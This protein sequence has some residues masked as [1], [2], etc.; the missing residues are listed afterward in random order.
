MDEMEERSFFIY[1][2]TLAK[3][4]NLVLAALM[5]EK[6]QIAVDVTRDIFL[7]KKAAEEQTRAAGTRREFDTWLG[8]RAVVEDSP[9]TSILTS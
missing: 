5:A 6:L 4:K 3:L 7:W 1:K 2:D 8:Q 9:D